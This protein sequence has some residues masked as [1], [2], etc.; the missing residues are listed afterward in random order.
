MSARCYKSASVLMQ[1]PTNEILQR[2][3]SHQ[4]AFIQ[5]SHCA[6]VDPRWTHEYIPSAAPTGIF[7]HAKDFPKT[8]EVDADARETQLEFI[9]CTYEWPDVF[10]MFLQYFYDHFWTS[11]Q[12]EACTKIPAWTP[13]NAKFSYSCVHRWSQCEPSIMVAQSNGLEFSYILRINYV[14]LIIIR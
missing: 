9:R 1:R 12:C 14:R 5:A 7:L 8:P 13:Q 10:T 3:R 11:G 2:C 6:E 4:H